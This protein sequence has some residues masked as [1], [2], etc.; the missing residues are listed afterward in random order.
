VSFLLDTN[1]ISEIVKPRPNAGLIAWLADVDEDRTF[2]SVITLMELRYG[3]ERMP[4]GHKRKQLEQW[5]THDLPVR[6]E[7]RILSID[8]QAADAC[9]RLAAHS[10][11]IGRPVET[12]DGLIAATAEAHGLTV[13]T[14]NVSNFKAVVKNLL[15]PWAE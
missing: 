7:S 2:L 11:A 8:E 4:A 12:R 14:R 3:T 13:V 6:F 10:Q 15:N 9:G 1:V 5:L